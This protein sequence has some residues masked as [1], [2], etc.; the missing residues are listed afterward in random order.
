MSDPHDAVDA[1]RRT[2]L[3]RNLSFTLM[4]TSTAASGFGDRMIMLA[5][6][7]LLGGL[8]AG[9]DNRAGIQA[10]TQFFFFVPYI[11]FSIVGGWLADHVPRKWLLLACDEARGVILFTCFVL[12][13]A[14]TGSADMPR[15]TVWF[16]LGQFDVPRYWQVYVAL[17]AIGVFAAIFNPT[18]S[19][20][21]PQIV[22][23]RQLQG[24]NAVILGINVVASMIGMIVGGRIIDAESAPSVRTGL[25][26]GAAFYLVSGSFFAF[27]RV[28]CHEVSAEPQQSRSFTKG[29]RYLRQHRRAISYILLNILVWSSAAAVST[30]FIGIGSVYYGLS[31]DDVKDYFTNMSATVGAGMLA[32]AGVIVGIRTRR[33][34]A[35]VMMAAMTM[36]GLSILLLVAVPVRWAGFVCAFGLGVF[37][38]V[39]IVSVLTMLQTATPN[40][41]RGRIMGIN[42]MAT[43]MFSVLTYFTIWRLPRPDYT[44]TTALFVI[45]PILMLIGMY[46]GIGHVMS[47][48][49][50]TRRCNVLWRITRIFVLIWHR[51]HWEGRENVPHDGPVILASNHT[52]GL[53]PML[54]QAAVPRVI[55]WVMLESF[56]FSVL[57]WF[58]N[59]IEPVFLGQD[60]KKM[61][62]IRQIVRRLE[63]GE[64]VG[65]FPEGGL[66]RTDRS[67]QRFHPGVVRIAQRAGAMIVPVWIEGTPMRDTM[68][69]HFLQPSQSV[70]R[71]G[72]PYRPDP[73]ASEQQATADLRRRI[74][75]LGAVDAVSTVDPVAKPDG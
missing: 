28:R 60:G 66:Q 63:Q 74:E 49:A 73:D 2:P 3:W 75:Q 37:G 29:L 32:G 13:Y 5:A 26:I 30:S 23:L 51:L 57:N 36:A 8:V 1:A 44:L 6:L 10:S 58:W 38:N 18:R 20:I 56:R 7:A 14:A 12:L 22:P 59:T 39:A 54:L 24:A 34:S 64:I 68:M 15:D 71:F 21:V 48:P 19:A 4:W 11:V 65:M 25:L 72:K 47:G 50:P 62:N 70:V 42:A 67:L 69:W 17:F 43:T 55:R 35:L 16:T 31:G 27:M 41:V 45:G 52:T 40:Y 9:I 33:E 53:D 46:A 61:S